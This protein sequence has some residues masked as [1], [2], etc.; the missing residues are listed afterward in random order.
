[1]AKTI[2]QSKSNV[3]L[4]TQQST[5]VNEKCQFDN[6]TSRNERNFNKKAEAKQNNDNSIYVFDKQNGDYFEHSTIADNQFKMISQLHFANPVRKQKKILW[7]NNQAGQRQPTK[8][9]QKIKQLE[10]KINNE[11]AVLITQNSI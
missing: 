8:Q 4:Q 2:N 10:K 9:K 7:N 5:I 6:S 11:T 1:M 3:S